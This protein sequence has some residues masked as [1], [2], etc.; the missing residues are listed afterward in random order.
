MLAIL[1]QISLKQIAHSP[2]V[3]KALCSNEAH[4]SIVMPYDW[5]G[6]EDLCLERKF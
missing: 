6:E 4:K 2:N 5:E 3:T 1:T